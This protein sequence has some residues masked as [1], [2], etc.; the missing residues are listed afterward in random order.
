MPKTA[1][2]T[3]KSLQK[4]KKNVSLQMFL[5]IFFDFISVKVKYIV[6]C[7]FRFSRYNFFQIW[8]RIFG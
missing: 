5:L 2:K 4:Y 1:Y 3:C 8:R 6:F 7:Y